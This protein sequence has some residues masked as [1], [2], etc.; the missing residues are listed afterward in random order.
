[1]SLL[2]SSARND[3]VA[4]E[5][6]ELSEQ[7]PYAC[8]QCGKCT[9]VCPFTFAMDILPHQVVRLLQLGQVDK[10]MES[11]TPWVCVG[12]LTC[13]TYCPKGL[14]PAR[15]MEAVR[16]IHLRRLESP[17]NYTQEDGEWLST[18]PQSALVAAM[19]KGTW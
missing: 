11:N 12:C 9:A 7:N 3:E 17:F 6:A 13:T 19:R 4:G 1:M 8:Y 16:T 14:D 5:V 2:L 10:V 18:L 15:I